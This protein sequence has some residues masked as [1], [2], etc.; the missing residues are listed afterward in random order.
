V[1]KSDISI[2]IALIA[3]SIT[4]VLASAGIIVTVL[5]SHAA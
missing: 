5:L 1:D 4:V 3:V 2:I